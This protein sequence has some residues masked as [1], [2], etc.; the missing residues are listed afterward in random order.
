MRKELWATVTRRM[1]SIGKKKRLFAIRGR[2]NGEKAVFLAQ[3]RRWYVRRIKPGIRTLGTGSDTENWVQRQ[4]SQTVLGYTFLSAAIVK[5][6]STKFK[7][8]NL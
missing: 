3:T 1:Y 4:N 7:S 6:I 5:S 2:M 8:T